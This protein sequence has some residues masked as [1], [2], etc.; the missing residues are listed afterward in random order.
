MTVAA[1]CLNPQVGPARSVC[2]ASCSGG[3]W[4]QGPRRVKVDLRP[5]QQTHGTALLG[6]RGA[7]TFS[8]RPDA[9]TGW[10]SFRRFNWTGRRSLQGLFIFC[11]AGQAPNTRPWGCS[12]AG[13]RPQQAVMGSQTPTPHFHLMASGRDLNSAALRHFQARLQTPR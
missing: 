13:R 5:I 7:I 12:P 6:S 9:T 1:P 4:M 2:A 11:I 3:R 8:I 10:R